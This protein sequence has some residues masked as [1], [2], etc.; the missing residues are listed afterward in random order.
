MKIEIINTG[1]FAL[2]G[3]AMFG[4][5]PK[6]LWEKQLTADEQN[7]IPLGL[8]VLLIQ[9]GNKNIIVDAGMGDKWNDKLKTIYNYSISM[10]LPG[11]NNLGLEPGDITDVIMTHMHFDHIGGLT[12]F[13]ETGIPQLTFPNATHHVNKTQWLW[14]N[15]ASSRDIASYL[16]ENFEP[17]IDH[18]G[19][20]LLD[21]P[22]ELFP[23]IE[24]LV[25]NGHTP[26]QQLVKIS[27]D[28][29]WMFMG[30]LV[31]THHHLPIPYVMGYDLE[32]LKTIAEKEEILKLAA[33]E[34]WNLVFEHDNQLP[35]SQIHMGKRHFEVK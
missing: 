35:S 34:S 10:L 11:L 22:G 18:K 25:V 16:K 3:G 30:D 4:V 23:N 29:T 33:E 7:R 32:P 12:Y 26:G 19:L 6:M 8:N 28:K 17:L 15:N 21:G 2:D 13:D 9:T 27:A 5:V 1:E 31:P 20:N 14:A 24:I